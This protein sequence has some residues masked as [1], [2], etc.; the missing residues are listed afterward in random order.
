[1]KIEQTVDEDAIHLTL[2]AEGVADARL[3]DRLAVV[4]KG[5]RGGPAVALT[6]VLDVYD[7]WEKEAA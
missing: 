5:V 2:T 7:R 4:L 6:R 3:L 1:M